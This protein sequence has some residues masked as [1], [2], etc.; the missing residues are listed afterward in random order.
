METHRVTLTLKG[1]AAM[2]RKRL[3]NKKLNPHAYCLSCLS[4]AEGRSHAPKSK[5]IPIN[6]YA[7]D[8]YLSISQIETLLKRKEI[9]GVKI[10]N[11][12]YIEEN[13]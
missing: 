9:K 4:H 1:K 3:Y 5:C 8:H 2:K 11:R 12:M 13:N 7:R 10:R 6:R